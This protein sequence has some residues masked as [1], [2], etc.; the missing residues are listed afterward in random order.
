MPT[1]LTHAAVPLAVGLGLGRPRI[2]R[3]LLA[4]G[5]FASICPDFD[6]VAFKLG[7]AYTDALGHRG[8]T[9]SIVF[10]VMLAVFAALAARPLQARRAVAAAF[11]FLS[12]VSHT[13]LDMFT[14]GGLGVA[15]FWP[16]S[17]ERLFAAWR[18]IEVS[19]I[20]VQRIFSARGLTVLLSELQWVWVP[21]LIL[22]ALIRVL[23]KRHDKLARHP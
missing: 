23:S 15:L 14:D 17:D 5:V 19:P 4:A 9:H 13:L 7:I 18:F 12:A 8:A 2:S 22:C 6:V 10:A 16:W 3:R 11:V 20:G 21:S 1:I